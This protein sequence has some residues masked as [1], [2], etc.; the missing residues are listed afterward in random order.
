M[1]DIDEPFT[2]ELDG[3]RYAQA[4]RVV[5]ID[6]LALA[7][8]KLEVGGRTALVVVGGASGMS[9]HETRR[10]RPVFRD[11]LAPVAQRLDASVIDGG[12]DVG[13]MQLMGTARGEA[14]SRFPLIGVL[15]D[16]LVSCSSTS[17]AQAVALE[18]HH[19]DFVLVPGSEWGEEARWLARLAT[20]VATS[21]GSA[22]VLVNGGETAVA[23]VRHSVEAG[24]HV[25]VLD[26][27]GRT[28]DVLA[29][30]VRGECADP[31]VT[32]LAESGLLHVVDSQDRNELACLLEDLLNGRAAE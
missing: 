23:D 16:D 32:S 7:A 26:G 3:G 8:H 27:S 1:C 18:P 30:A 17:D 2:V 10:L 9:P 15:V 19:T 21:H 12:T 25:A 20:V 22:T 6:D 4:V 24:R 14:G 13:V 5:A 28:A 31:S 29:A 11:V